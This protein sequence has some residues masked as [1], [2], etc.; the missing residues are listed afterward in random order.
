M[1]V[2]I[3]KP[4]SYKIAST[5]IDYDF[6][7]LRKDQRFLATKEP[8]DKA[9]TGY[10]NWVGDFDSAKSKK[11]FIN[12]HFRILESYP[13][14][15]KLILDAFHVFSSNVY[16]PKKFEISTSW[17]NE[18]RDGEHIPPHNHTN[19]VFSGVLYY[20]TYDEKSAILNLRNPID[21]GN[22]LF[23]QQE[24]EAQL[25]PFTGG[26]YFFPALMMHSSSMHKGKE[27]YSLA[28][29]F[30]L[31]EPV[32]NYDSSIDLSWLSS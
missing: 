11:D 31:T 19:C 25:R 2:N 22:D 14:L 1:K 26:C 7:E 15:K 8:K 18:I 5:E 20:D 21:I 10:R 30:V 27:R 3:H 24:V 12:K 16:G 23:C 4:F 13:D 9:I 17:L 32:Y 28:F 29:N 6:T